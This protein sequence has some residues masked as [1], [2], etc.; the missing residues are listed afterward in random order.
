[1]HWLYRLRYSG[2]RFILFLTAYCCPQL[3]PP[4][5][6]LEPH[7]RAGGSPTDSQ[8]I[9]ECELWWSGQCHR[10][11]LLLV[12]LL[13]K[14]QQWWLSPLVDA[15]LG[16]SCPCLLQSNFLLGHGSPRS[17]AVVWCAVSRSGVFSW[18]G[19]GHQL[20]HS[21]ETR[22][23]LQQFLNIPLQAPSGISQHVCSLYVTFSLPTALLL[24]RGFL[25]PAKRAHLS[26]VE[27]QVWDAQAVSLL[28][29]PESRSPPR[30]IGLDLITSSL[31]A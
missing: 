24:V 6:C 2:S 16:L 20:G 7:H 8:H 26:C 12:F 22:Q 31:P 19:L 10:S 29:T 5:P 4:L 23:L 18:L 14:H 1:M 21:L 28:L 9:L 17:N 30:G 11:G 25:Q 3:L 15:A 13:S 27:A